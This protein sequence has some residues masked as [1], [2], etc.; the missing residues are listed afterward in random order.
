[1]VDV[2]LR[3]IDDETL[4]TL[5][6]VAVDDADPDEVMPPSAGPPGWTRARRQAFRQFHRARRAGLDAP[7]RELGLAIVAKGEV[8]GVARLRRRDG[9]EYEI[10]AW[11]G[12][13]H[14]GQGVGTA[15]LAE[16]MSIAVAW[17]ATHLVADTTSANAAALAVL[18]HHDAVL[19]EP[20]P[21]GHVKARL[22]G[23][24]AGRVQP[25]SRPA[26]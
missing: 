9:G 25:P 16:L 2:A 22:R 12:R 14:R 10:G 5:V 6:R 11:I 20:D 23:Q 17:G 3:P 15:A 21:T 1:M 13:S 8:V 26:P 4:D 18:R 24:A 19:S 7:H